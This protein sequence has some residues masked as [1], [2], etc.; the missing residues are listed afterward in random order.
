MS[1]DPLRRLCQRLSAHPG[2]GELAA[3][4]AAFAALPPAVT[5][6]A[7]HLP[8]LLGPRPGPWWSENLLDEEGCHLALFLL[9]RG[10][11]LPLHDHPDMHV[12][13]RVLHGRL[14]VRAFDWVE[15]TPPR[16]R[17]AGELVVAP[18]SAPLRA[19]PQLHNVHELRAEEPSAILDLFAPY[20]DKEAGRPCHYWKLGT[21]HADGTR[22]LVLVR[23]E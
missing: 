9:P 7:R 12:W 22:S 18:G 2:E 3:I 17:P 8:R 4:D 15:R 6:L 21:A 20:Y 11:R 13:T 19:T 14:A 23:E 16:V 10:E 5:S 1:F